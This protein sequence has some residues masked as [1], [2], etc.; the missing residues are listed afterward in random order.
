MYGKL[1]FAPLLVLLLSAAWVIAAS[2]GDPTCAVLSQSPQGLTVRLSPAV[3]TAADVNTAEAGFSQWVL[4]PDGCRL[5]ARLDRADGQTLNPEAV[6]VNRAARLRH[7]NLS[8][9]T[10]SP[11]RLPE[12]TNPSAAVDVRLSFA[13]DPTA[14]RSPVANR[15]PSPHVQKLIESLV[16]NP[17]PHRDDREL[18]QRRGFNEYYLFVLPERIG[19]DEPEAI[20]AMVQRLID[21]KRAAGNQVELLRIPDGE[22]TIADAIDAL[23]Q[24]RYDELLNQGEEPFDNI[25]L[26]GEDELEPYQGN[27]GGQG[28]D[29]LLVGPEGRMEVPP[30]TGHFDLKY[31][32]LEGGEDDMVAD[33]AISRFHA[34][35]AAML[36]NAVCKTISY[37]SAP[38]MEDTSWFTKGVVQEEE[39]VNSDP[40]VGFTV[41]CLINALH[42]NSIDVVGQFRGDT[43]NSSNWL[44]RQFNTRINFALGRAQNTGLCYHR[45]VRTGNMFDAVNA[46]PIT[47]MTSGHGEWSME[48]MF[49]VG[50]EYYD[51][52]PERYDDARGAKGSVV[53]TSVWSIPETTPNNLLAMGMTHGMLDLGLSFGWARNWTLL[54]LA[55]VYPDQPDRFEKYSDDFAICGEPG[56]VA[57]KQAPRLMAVDYPQSL[58]RGCSR[59]PVVVTDAVSGFP[60]KDALVTLRIGSPEE[61]ELFKLGF[62]DSDGR[63]EFAID[64][65][66]FGEIKITAV[67]PGRY[68]FQDTIARAEEAQVGI[69]I[70]SIE[71]RQTGNGDGQVNPGETVSLTFSAFNFLAERIQNLTATATSLSEYLILSDDELRFGSI[72]QLGEAQAGPIT[73]TVALSC[74]DGLAQNFMLSMTDGEHN[75]EAGLEITPV[76]WRLEAELAADAVLPLDAQEL[77]VELVNLGWIESPEFMARLETDCW[78]M[79]VTED[80]RYFAPVGPGESSGP[81]SPYGIEIHDAALPGMKAPMTLVLDSDGE[82]FAR[83][84]FTIQLGEAGAGAP[85]G[86]DDYGY[87]AFDNTDQGFD[88]TP[89]YLW[90]EISPEDDF[91]I[92]GDSLTLQHGDVVNGWGVIRLP[93]PFQFY[94]RTYRS[95]TVCTNGFI[96]VGSDTTTVAN[97]QNWPLDD[98]GLGGGYGIIAPFWDNLS[99]RAHHSNIYWVYDADE[100]LFI[101]EWYNVIFPATEIPLNFEVIIFNPATY[102]TATGDAKI[103]FQ[104]RNIQQY[105]QVLSESTP[106]ATVGLSNPDG[107][108]GFT[109]SCANRYPAS[110]TP[111]TNQ[112]AIL[113]TTTP[114]EMHGT[115]QGVVCDANWGEPIPGAQVITANGRAESNQNGFWRIENVFAGVALPVFVEKEGFFQAEAPRV[116][117]P[118]NGEKYVALYLTEGQGATEKKPLPTEFGLEGVYPNPFNPTA[119]VRFS[120]DREQPMILSV[121]DLAGREVARLH[122]GLAAAGAHEIVWNAASQPSG[123]Y[124]VRLEG[125]SRAATKKVVLVK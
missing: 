79:N 3:S 60:V 112:R 16:I 5:E 124:L 45:G 84:N 118:E 33:A 34:G 103:L 8:Q 108:S 90:W 85:T 81:Q 67:K 120:L 113:F 52:H 57:W 89:Q 17:P 88:Q 21:W 42:H 98:G 86:P 59:I 107:K 72:E 35:N 80:Y 105:G 109:Y 27:Q 65:M 66:H 75:W 49:W 58:P 20:V 106:F 28:M 36:A 29:I 26:L 71:D 2:V 37:E 70:R 19:G 32:F 15:T 121:F 99:R 24:N 7:Y 39:L 53:V 62:T 30:W 4:V 94:G 100:D 111:L 115:L 51:G 77:N 122:E 117:V 9:F 97:F 78:G 10:V 38:Y 110:A 61:E 125:A 76:G 55:K 11:S 18:I 82:E 69:W 1:S 56:L 12:G 50:R 6:V 63:C 87:W 13:L 95:L 123:V 83:V 41:D 96:A 22:D 31:A 14:P 48:A 102:P 104:Y 46:F 116:I 91:D 54:Y 25:L 40:S 73:A 23:I 47:I 44:A 119:K 114:R 64:P 68:P 93:F 92:A 74:P 43:L 101:V